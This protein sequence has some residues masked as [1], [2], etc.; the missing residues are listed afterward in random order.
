MDLDTT[1]T[2][3]VT[4]CSCRDYG[5]HAVVQHVF[6]LLL[7]LVTRLPDY[8]QAVCNGRW[9][10]PSQFFLPNLP[11]CEPVG[12]KLG[13]IGYGELGRGVAQIASLRHSGR[14]DGTQGRAD[15]NRPAP[16]RGGNIGKP[17]AAADSTAA[18]KC[19]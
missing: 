6:A 1:A 16:R 3:G 8:R 7:S 17:V 2:Q 13:I 14:G 9:Q 4:V 11:I 12:K 18:S 10:Y 15:V 19:A 5:T